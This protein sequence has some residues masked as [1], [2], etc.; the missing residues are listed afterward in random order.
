M[1]PSG[2]FVGIDVSNAQLP[3]LTTS[4]KS[5]STVLHQGK[6]ATA[7]ASPPA[8]STATTSI[9]GLSPMAGP[10]LTPAIPKS[11]SRM[12]PWLRNRNA[13]SGQ[14]LSSCLGITA[15]KRNPAASRGPTEKDIPFSAKPPEG[16]GGPGS[17]RSA[18]R[19]CRLGHPVTIP[20][21]KTP[22]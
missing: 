21:A 13:E 19:A 20:F 2:K 9:A 15:T 12:K 8:T 1:T 4:G 7:A 6:T 17:T 5:P 14:A 22:I 3:S 18:P 11:M 16:P 10:W